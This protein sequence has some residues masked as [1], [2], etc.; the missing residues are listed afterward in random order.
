MGPAPEI[1]KGAAFET[2]AI[3]AG[4]APDEMTGSVVPPIYAVST[5]AQDAVGEPRS[6]YVYG[7]GSNPTRA[8]LEQ[9]LATL[10]NGAAAI[11]FSSGMAAESGVFGTLCQPGDHVI[12]PADV[13]GGT[14]RLMDK[15]L[16]RWGLSYSAL[17]MSDLPAL[18]A[19]VRPGTTKIIWCE[20]PTN[21]LLELSDIAELA[22][23]ARGSGALLAVDNT[24]ASPYLQRPLEF[25]ADIVV[26]S[27][28]KYLGGHSDVI[29]GAVIARDE[30]VGSAIRSYQNATGAVPSPFDAWLTLRGI[31]TLSLRVS[32]Q[33]QTALRLAEELTSHPAVS[34][35]Y[36]P[37]L[38]SHPRHELALKQMTAFG[39]VLSFTTSGGESAALGVCNSV[40]LFTL[41]ESLGAVES[42]ISHPLRM[43]HASTAGSIVAPPDNLVRVSVGLESADDLARDLMMAL[44][45]TA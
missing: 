17:P 2:L 21:P 23:L 7:R 35:V 4:Q 38:A 19:A 44:D 26:H 8:A 40:Q 5:F 13:Y 11:A 34:R 31:K 45:S 33:S 37:G 6:G 24:F 42:L 22:K 15:I 29:G 36:Y 18:E 25:G 3:H 1:L 27:T 10:E 32:R 39:G 14:Y 20:T 12:I 41:A 43:T 16:Q 30:A 9:C 28:T